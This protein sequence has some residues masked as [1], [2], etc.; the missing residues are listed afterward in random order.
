MSKLQWDQTGEKLYETGV[1]NGAV[2]LLDQAGAYTPGYAWNGLT[3][4]D[5]KPSGA[6]STK[7]Y[8][9]NTV[10]ANLLSAE[11]FG[12]TIEAFTYPKEF[13]PCIGLSEI[14]TG[15]TVGQQ[16]HKTFG[17]T[18]KTLLGNDLDGTDHGY[19]LHL[20]YGCKAAP[21]EQSYETVNSSPDVMS[22]SFEITTTPVNVTGAKPT[23][24]LVI[25]STTADKTKLSALEDILYGTTT[26]TPR[27]PLPDEVKTLMTVTA[28]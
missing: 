11:E 16:T 15:V 21:A 18:Y 26:G 7:K 27:L 20:I 28:G 22:F 23:A 19:K 6:E 1:S 14:A 4:V 2:Y 17:L 25:D 5:E 9:D 24:S 10:Y 13:K 8:A 12:A 3:K